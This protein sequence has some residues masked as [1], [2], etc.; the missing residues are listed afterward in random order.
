MVMTGDTC[1]FDISQKDAKLRFSLRKVLKV[2][3]FKV[4]LYL[5][6]FH[7]LNTCITER[8]AIS[9]CKNCLRVLYI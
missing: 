1:E 4:G 6:K 7:M 8:S 2:H 5:T 3:N 9:L